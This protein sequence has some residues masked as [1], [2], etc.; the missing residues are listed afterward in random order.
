LPEPQ[1]SNGSVA[2][3]GAGQSLVPMSAEPASERLH[4]A[5][6]PRPG[7]LRERGESAL[8]RDAQR[9]S[10]DALEELFRRHWR[11]AHRAAYLVVGDAT[12]AEDIA[13]E[14]FLAAV[15]ALDRFDRR[16]PFG[17]WLHRITVNRAIDFARARALRAES[18]LT[19]GAEHSA[20]DRRELS[21]ALVAALAELAPEH[22]AV[23]VLRYVLEYTPGEIG[24]MLELPRGT[25]NSRLR[26]ALDR[27][28]P[29]VEEGRA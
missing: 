29:A 8:I 14:S 1:I 16:R 13:Q 17:P 20:A 5:A 26:R 12:A 10:T 4:P 15:R 9:G 3:A 7:R 6:L 21:D 25:V 24:A 11:R 2:L 27:L 23:V 28:R 19:E 22:R 18:A